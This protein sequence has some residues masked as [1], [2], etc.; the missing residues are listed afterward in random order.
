MLTIVMVSSFIAI[1]CGGTLVLR[2]KRSKSRSGESEKTQAPIREII[3]LRPN[4]IVVYFNE[5]YLVTGVV[6]WQDGG[7]AWRAA[8]LD[9]DDGRRRWLQSHQAGGHEHYLMEEVS[10]LPILDAPETLTYRNGHFTL[11]GW[12]LTTVAQEGVIFRDISH[13][14]TYYHYEGPGQRLITIEIWNDSTY[15]LWGQSI[16]PHHLELM[17]GDLV[18]TNPG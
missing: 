7:N 9:C 17:P 6:S 8:A 10:D 16:E 15:T 12:G 4:D 14:A 18:S 3:D 13:R 2:R 5:N 11:K 1:I